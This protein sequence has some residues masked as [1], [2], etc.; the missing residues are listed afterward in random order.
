[1]D[2][3]TKQPIPF[4][5][6]DTNRM[7]EDIPIRDVISLYTGRT[8]RGQSNISCPSPKHPDD[9]HPSAHVY[10]KDNRCKCFACGENFSPISLAKEYYPELSFPDLCQKLID[11][12]HLDVYSYS[13]KQEVEMA[14]DASSKN[15]FFDF[16]PVTEDDLNTIG[17][18]NPKRDLEFT[19]AVRATDYFNHFY[20]EIPPL[21]ETHDKDGNEIL[22]QC[23][24]GEAREMGILTR[25]PDKNHEYITGIP[26]IQELWR[27]DK[28][29]TEEMIVG[30]CHETID[31]L[32]C[33][34]ENAENEVETY[35]NTHTTNQIKEADKLRE[36]YIKAVA[37]GYDV[38]L[39]DAQREKINGL[40]EFEK[41]KSLISLYNQKLD[42]AKKVLKKVQ[43]HQQERKN[44][45]KASKK[46]QLG[47]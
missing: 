36:G 18:H 2:K 22:M 24:A 7:N 40:Y 5:R 8:V 39:S 34:I 23:S 3:R 6:Y 30:K 31:D 47:R 12:F 14:K 37:N 26:T 33:Q 45:Y 35:R 1:M 11:D 15:K 27:E 41:T 38:R 25:T 16:F 46:E 20:G 4:L 13:N 44:A 32:I 21:A 29:G 19:Y 17:L 43:E 10:D 28:K 42:S 9:K